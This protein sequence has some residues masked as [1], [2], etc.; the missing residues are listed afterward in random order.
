MVRK[1]GLITLYSLPVLLMIGL[2]PVVQNDYALTAVYCVFIFL[3][4][5]YKSEKK[6]T[7]RF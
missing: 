3:L 5:M 2:V 4:V 7:L 6:T 1:V